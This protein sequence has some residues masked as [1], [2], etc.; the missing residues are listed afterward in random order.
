MNEFKNE[1]TKSSS[2]PGVNFTNILRAPFWYKST[3]R[4]FSLLTV[5]WLCNFLSKEYWRKVDHWWHWQQISTLKTVKSKNM[6]S[7]GGWWK[8]CFYIYKKGQGLT[9]TL[10]WPVHLVSPIIRETFTEFV[11]LGWT[12]RWLFLCLFLPL[13]KQVVFFRQLGQLFKLAWAKK[14][15]TISMFSFSQ[16]LIRNVTIF[17]KLRSLKL[18]LLRFL[19]LFRIPES[20]LK[21]LRMN[22]K[23]NV[24]SQHELIKSPLKFFHQWFGLFNYFSPTFFTSFDITTVNDQKITN[25]FL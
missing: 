24:L 7:K 18:T 9:I 2:R 21:F 15:T 23:V 11:T 25:I 19:S 12:K 10:I 20:S 1:G 17:P 16:S 13:M 4:S 3:L 22:M 14:R 5:C 8:H 6:N